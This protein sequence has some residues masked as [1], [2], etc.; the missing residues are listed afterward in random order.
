M[1]GL[2]GLGPLAFVSS[3][4]PGE[5]LL[6]DDLI[7]RWKRSKEYT[8]AVLDAMPGEK[9]EYRPTEEQMSFAQ[10]FMHLGFTNNSFIGVLLD[11]KSYADFDALME[12]DFFLDRP[13]PVNLF[14]PDVMQERSPEQNM[15]M[16]SKYVSDTF[17]YVISG[18]DTLSDSVLGR[19]TNRVKPWF[20]E[21][22]SN[23]DLILRSE[24][25][26]AHHRAQAI[27][28]LRLNGIRPPGYSRYNTL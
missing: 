10:H 26:T 5:R 20:L 1:F 18:L 17:D 3:K 22:H 11:P 16:V 21:G 23:L 9:L 14:E 27:C 15:D 24:A 8:L 6:V 13:D 4:L 25:H 12:A 7:R 19:G 28:Y 2:I